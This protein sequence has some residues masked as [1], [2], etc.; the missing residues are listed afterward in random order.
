MRTLV[1]LSFLFLSSGSIRGQ[2]VSHLVISEVYGGGG[3]AGATY[4]N[5]FIEIYNP[6]ASTVD[7]TGWSVQYASGTS[8]SWNVTELTGSIPAYS[9]YLVQEAAGSGGTVDLPTPDATGSLNLGGSSGKIALVNSITPLADANPSASAYIDLVGYGSANGYEGSE[10]M[11][12]LSNTQSAERRAR[13]SSTAS[14]MAPGGEDEAFGNGYDT[15][16]NG[17]DFVKQ[18]A[19]TPQNSS[20]SETPPD[21]SLPV[22]MRGLTATVENGKVL[23]AFSTASEIDIAGFNVLRADELDGPFLVISSYVTNPS[24]KASGDGA[25]S[26]QYSFVDSKVKS[27]QT[28]YYKIEA[29]NVSGNT[30]KAGEI[31]G[32][33]VEQPESFM[34][35]Q[36]YPNPFNPSTVIRFNVPGSGFVSLKLYD[37]LGRVVKTLVNGVKNSGS[38]EIEFNAADLPGGLYFCEMRVESAGALNYSAIRKMVLLK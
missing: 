9:F 32:V 16:D 2:V 31:L 22:T 20:M 18:D 3:N 10:P 35:F 26:A 14:S 21:V 38:Y 7:L 19:V 29:V 6:S 25:S 8:D 1:V 33:Q 12:S 30:E 34:L 5:D 17:T 15:D 13:S 37:V 11:P 27:G 36:N 24:L 28:Y 23:L 4:K